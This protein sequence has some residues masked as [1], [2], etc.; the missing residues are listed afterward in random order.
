MDASGKTVAQ[1][2]ANLE[3]AYPGI[4]ERLME[5]GDLKS[6]I[7]VA[8]DGEVSPLGLEESVKEQSEVHFIPAISGGQRCRSLVTEATPDGVPQG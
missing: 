8:V 7:S 2:I 4:K 6:H 1:V 5:D 3:K